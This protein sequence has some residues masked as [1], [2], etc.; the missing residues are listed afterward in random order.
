[1]GHEGLEECAIAVIVPMVNKIGHLVMIF[2]ILSNGM[3]DDQLCAENHCLG[4]LM[5]VESRTDEDHRDPR[6]DAKTSR[7]SIYD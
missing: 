7:C 2:S 5:E 4:I 1:M 6:L 3:A